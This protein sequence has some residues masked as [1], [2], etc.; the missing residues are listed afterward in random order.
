M[1]KRARWFITAACGAALILLGLPASGQVAPDDKSNNITQLSRVAATSPATNS[2]LAFYSDGGTTYTVA[3]NYGGFRIIDTTD[4]SAPVVVSDFPCNGPQN[5]VSVIQADDG[6][7]YLFQSID[8]PQTSEACDSTSTSFADTP[9][10]F[11][12]V[13]IFD[14]TDPANPSLVDGVPTDCGS[15]THTLVPGDETSLAGDENVA[16]IY[17]SSYPLSGSGVTGDTPNANGTECKRPHKKISIIKVDLA[18]PG[19]ADDQDPMTGAYP[20]VFERGQDLFT[21]T[22]DFGG[23]VRFAGCHDIGVAL[24]VNP[25]FGN[26]GDWAAGACFE[27][28]QLWDISDPT[29]PSFVNRWRNDNGTTV[30][31][32]HTASFTWDGKM[33]I[34]GDEAGGGGGN[35]CRYTKDQQGRFWFHEFDSMRPVGSFKIP[36][37]QA[38]NCTA[39]ILNMIPNTAGRYIAASSWYDGGTSVID[40]TNPTEG[41]EVAHYDAGDPRANVWATY[42]YNGAFYANDIGRGVEI[43]DVDYGPLSKAIDF[44]EGE[45]NPQTQYGMFDTSQGCTVFGSAGPDVLKGTS[46]ADVICGF[47]GK[48]EIYGFGGADTLKGGAGDDELFGGRGNDVLKGN[49]GDDFMNGGKGNDTCK[50]GRGKDKKKSC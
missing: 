12:G 10:A 48:D 21:K 3:A 15:H 28:A 47:G 6:N 50:G 35:R 4:P 30:D 5:D 11:E 37:A 40:F 32:Y 23:D 2:D 44:P 24:G 38:G 34:F 13:R 25:N 18:N 45:M 7:W 43:Y 42:W 31:L 49:A 14:I 19:S 33:L 22:S 29:N 8:T 9:N 20:N 41:K 27:E 39:H 26:P 36:R 1:R 46:G 17:V 16:Y